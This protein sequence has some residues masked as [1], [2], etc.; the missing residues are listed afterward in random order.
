MVKIARISESMIDYK[1]VF[2][3]ARDNA[4]ES[5]NDAISMAAS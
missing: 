2:S 4:N 5:V 3:S 1:K